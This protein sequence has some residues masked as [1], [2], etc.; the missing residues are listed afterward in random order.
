MG[1]TPDTARTCPVHGYTE[2]SARRKLQRHRDRGDFTQV[3]RFHEWCGLWHVGELIED[4]DVEWI[5]P[6]VRGRNVSQEG[7]EDG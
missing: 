6:L 2:T 1:D 7:H 5:D 3:M 4:D